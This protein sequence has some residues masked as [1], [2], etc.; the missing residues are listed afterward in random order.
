MDVKQHLRYTLDQIAKWDV[1]C[2]NNGLE[3]YFRGIILLRQ[4]DLNILSS[5]SFLTAH[6]P[7]LQ[8]A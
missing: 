1:E 2:H 6:I 3:G 5:C 8:S 4:H 7:P